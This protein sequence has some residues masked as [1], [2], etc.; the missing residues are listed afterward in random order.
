MSLLPDYALPPWL[1][2]ECSTQ[3]Y[4]R[5]RGFLPVPPYRSF[6]TYGEAW[7]AIILRWAV[8]WDAQD[9]DPTTETYP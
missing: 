5:R 6:R 8:Q 7:E 2:F 1:V 9:P 3:P 4:L